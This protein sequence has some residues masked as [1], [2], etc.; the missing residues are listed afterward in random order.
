MRLILT[1]TLLSLL[2]AGSLSLAVTS[3]GAN[4][5]QHRLLVSPAALGEEARAI[6]EQFA[7][8]LHGELQQALE[9]G[10]A[11]SAIEVCRERAPAIAAEL[12]ANGWSIKRVSLEPLNPRNAADNLERHALRDFVVK[13]A[14]GW[15]AEQLAY[16]KIHLLQ[17]NDRAV[18]EFRYIKAIPARTMCLTCHGKSIAPDVQEKFAELYPQ[19][20]ARG[21]QLDD[22]LGAYSLQKDIVS[23][24]PES[25]HTP[26]AGTNLAGQ[27]LQQSGR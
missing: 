16:Y 6:I 26:A 22:I 3:A 11:V 25:A 7:K 12:S 17:I 23:T 27:A 18:S 13:K 19:Y 21:Y 4:P 20:Q 15:K 10:G 1:T 24:P 8:R 5:V 9:N 14:N 2:S